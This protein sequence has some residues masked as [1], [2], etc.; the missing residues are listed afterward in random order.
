MLQ[1]RSDGAPTFQ[2]PLRLNTSRSEVDVPQ[3]YVYSW[4]QSTASQSLIHLVF[5]SDDNNQY[6]LEDSEMTA[7]ICTVFLS[8]HEFP[9]SL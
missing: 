1:G 2:L 5:Q 3:Q 4:D 9:L 7:E 8:L 6:V